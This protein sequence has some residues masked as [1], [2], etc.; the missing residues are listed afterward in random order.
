MCLG[1]EE[2]EDA[3]RTGAITEIL[4]AYSRS[5]VHAKKEYVQSAVRLPCH[6]L[7]GLHVSSCATAVHKP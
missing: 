6:A 4:V 2:V 3:L 1:R 5:P 7:L